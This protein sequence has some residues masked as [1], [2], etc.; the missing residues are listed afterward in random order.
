MLRRR[1]LLHPRLKPHRRQSLHPRLKL[2]RR[3]KQHRPQLL[4]RRLMPRRRQLAQA[5]KLHSRNA[6]AGAL[7]PRVLQRTGTQPDIIVRLAPGK[8]KSH[9]REFVAFLLLSAFALRRTWD[10]RSRSDHCDHFDDSDA[11]TPARPG[12]VAC[13]GGLRPA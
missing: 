6:R 8:Q 3:L 1:L 5:S 12:V 2:L 7:L 9:G 11:R 10:V 4:L 13:R